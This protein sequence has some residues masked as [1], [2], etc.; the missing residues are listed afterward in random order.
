MGDGIR[1]TGG[2]GRGVLPSK[3][4]PWGPKNKKNE[5]CLQSALFTGTTA[6]AADDNNILRY[7]L[8]HKLTDKV[9][10]HES[11]EN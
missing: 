9:F 10:P 6:A 8:Q 2:S 11:A 7:Q 3:D 5:T 1:G 4:Q